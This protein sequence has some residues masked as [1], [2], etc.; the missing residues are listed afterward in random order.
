MQDTSL[1]NFIITTAITSGLLL[2]IAVTDW[3]TQRIPNG[4]TGALLAWAVVQALWR[5]QPDLRMLLTGA[6]AGGGLFWLLHR[7][8]RGA[9]GLGDV[10]LALAG[11][12]LLGWPAVLSA[13]L[14]AVLMGGSAAAWLLLSGRAQRH[15]RFAYGPYLALA[16][17]AVYL[18]SG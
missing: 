16:I 13:L 9:L 2:A 5:G 1:F 14:G 18:W 17:W 8:G 15:E 7:L 10:K 12:A 11:G 4:L 6:V 3:R